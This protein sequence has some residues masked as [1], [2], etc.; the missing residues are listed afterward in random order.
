MPMKSELRLSRH[1][2]VPGALVAEIWYDGQFIGEVVGADGPG[3]RV[4]SKYIAEVQA[5][6]GLSGSLVGPLTPSVVTVRLAV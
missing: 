1:D 4:I 6:P 5:E 3:V 2:V